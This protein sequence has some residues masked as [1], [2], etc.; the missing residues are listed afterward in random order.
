MPVGKAGKITRMIRM[1]PKLPQRHLLA[2]ITLVEGIN[3]GANTYGAASSFLEGDDRR[4]AIHSLD[5]L[6]SLIGTSFSAREY[7]EAARRYSK[8][9][10]V[11]TIPVEGERLVVGGGRAPGFPAL[12]NTDLTLNISPTSKA[13]IVADIRQIDT[14][15]VGK[16]K[17]VFF[18]RLPFEV[19]DE[20]AISNAANLLKPGGKLHIIT[21]RAA[22]RNKLREHLEQAGFTDIQIAENMDRALE[23]V[24]QLRKN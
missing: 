10:P 1:G 8:I 15:K 5:A 7:L 18:E 23:I 22:N 9:S 24:A 14:S 20:E 4:G 12:R 19:I 2:A 3:L 13:D 11:P 6:F 17:E 21:G 16:F